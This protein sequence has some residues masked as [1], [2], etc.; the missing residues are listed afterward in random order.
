MS[1]IYCH[2]H[3]NS[4]LSA[5]SHNHSLT[6]SLL[7]VHL[8]TG[9]K[10]CDCNSQYTGAVVAAVLEPVV[11]IATVIAIVVGITRWRKHSSSRDVGVTQDEQGM[12]NGVQLANPNVNPPIPQN[13][14]NVPPGEGQVQPAQDGQE[15]NRNQNLDAIQSPAEVARNEQEIYQHANSCVILPMD[16][17]RSPVEAQSATV[18][19]TGEDDVQPAHGVQ[20]RD[21]IPP[22]PSPPLPPPPAN[23]RE[24]TTNNQPSDR[25]GDGS[26]QLR[27]PTP[28]SDSPTL[29]KEEHFVPAPKA[30]VRWQQSLPQERPPFNEELQSQATIGA[31]KPRRGSHSSRDDPDVRRGSVPA[32]LS[33]LVQ[34]VSASPQSPRSPNK[35]RKFSISSSSKRQSQI[36]DGE[37]TNLLKGLSPVDDEHL[38]DGHTSD[39][40]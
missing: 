1:I 16:P 28:D 20:E 8:H 12:D 34:V 31:L 27:R 13:A 2:Q 18:P 10:E 7:T 22:P 23:A 24:A 33:P 9:I 6:H 11:I 21:A 19:P 15:R 30:S 38:G 25:V 29:D 37:K 35:K 4:S 3:T 40:P 26:V 17:I 32:L 5:T 36:E 39:D 14:N